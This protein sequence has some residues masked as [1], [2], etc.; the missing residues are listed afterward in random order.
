MR[1]NPNPTL[2]LLD[3]L[4]RTREDEQSAM[5]EMASGR[6]VNSPSD[7]PAAAAVLVQNHARS[8]QADQFKSSGSNLSYQLQTVDSTL[9]SVVLALQRAISLGD[10]CRNPWELVAPAGG[11]GDGG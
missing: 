2:D 8:E 7:D 6:R 5:L 1:V 10:Q 4:S 3:A 9:N 11:A